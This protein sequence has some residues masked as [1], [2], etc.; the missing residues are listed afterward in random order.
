MSH[1]A[2]ESQAISLLLQSIDPT[3]PADAGIALC[4]QAVDLL[5]WV[6][7]HLGEPLRMSRQIFAA[8]GLGAVSLEPLRVIVL[9]AWDVVAPEH[10]AA[11]RNAS[12]RHPGYRGEARLLGR[13]WTEIEVQLEEL[14][15]IYL[16]ADHNPEIWEYRE[17]ERLRLAGFDGNALLN[18]EGSEN[19]GALLEGL[20]DGTY[21]V[22]L[23]DT[24]LWLE[25]E[26]EE[27]L[28]R[29]EAAGVRVFRV[30]DSP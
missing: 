19:M 1:P 20:K 27:A 29:A 21:P 17:E 11:L 3:Q 9:V 23:V 22:G 15:A 30:G 2:P 28:E 8:R 7:P 10:A 6:S 26:E 16:A 12:A 25:E 4:K 5:L 13:T 24:A 14:P 18:F